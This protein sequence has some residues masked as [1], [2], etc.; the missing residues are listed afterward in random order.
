VSGVPLATYMTSRQELVQARARLDNPAY[1]FALTFLSSYAP[2]IA[3]VPGD[4]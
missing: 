2:W 1:F 4:P 3:Q